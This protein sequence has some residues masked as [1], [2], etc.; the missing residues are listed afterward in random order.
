MLLRKLFGTD[1][2]ISYSRAD[3]EYAKKLKEQ[4]ASMDYSCFIDY[5]KVFAGDRLSGALRRAI[6]WSSVLVLIGTEKSRASKFVGQEV[7][8][9]LKTKRPMVPICLGGALA[10]S[11]W[12]VIHDNDFVWVDEPNTA[13]P[14]PVVLDE[15]NRLFKHNRVKVWRRTAGT[16]LTL[17]LLALSAFAAI[18]AREARAQQALAEQKTKEAEQKTRDLQ[19]KQGELEAS[20][21]RLAEQR[22]QLKKQNEDLEKSK[23]ELLKKTEEARANADRARRQEQLARSNAARAREQQLLAEARQKEALSREVASSALSL[24]ASDPEL[25]V[26]LA[27]EALNIKDTDQAQ[28]ALR[29]AVLAFPSRAV[30]CEHRGVV[31]TG[32]FSAD[33]R[34]AVTGSEEGLARV[35]DVATGAKVAEVGVA[36]APVVKAEFNPKAD[37]LLTLDNKQ[38]ARLWEVQGQR[39]LRV[40]GTEGEARAAAFSPDG[41]SVLTTFGDH[42]A[43]VYATREGRELKVLRGHTGAV[44]TAEF[45]RDGTL[46]VTTGGDGTARVWSAQTGEEL[47]TLSAKEGWVR[48]AS[49]GDPSFDGAKF[50]RDGRLVITQNW[51][52]VRVWDWRRG[53]YVKIGGSKPGAFFSI[54]FV[55]LSPDGRLVATGGNTDVEPVRLWK[56]SDG[57]KVLETDISNV[58]SLEFSPDGAYLLLSGKSRAF[59]T[60]IGWN[61]DRSGSRVQVWDVNAGRQVFS[62]DGHTDFVNSARFSPDG[63]LI[64]TAGDDQT[65]RVWRFTLGKRVTELPKTWRLDATAFSPDGRYIIPRGWGT[66]HD[67][68]VWETHT[69]RQWRNLKGHDRKVLRASFS[70]DGKK[71]VSASV[72]NTA[73]VWDAETGTVLRTF[74]KHIDQFEDVAEVGLNDVTFNHD[75]TLIATAGNDH[76]ARLWEESTGKELFALPHKG[77]VLSVAFSPSG[78]YLATSAKDDTVHVWDVRTGKEVRSLGGEPDQVD[79]V[80][81]SPLGNYILLRREVLSGSPELWE[82]RAGGVVQLPGLGSSRL[83]SVELSA[84]ERFIVT[85]GNDQTA[86]VWDVSTRKQLWVLPGHTSTVS[87]ATFSPDGR[88]I[89]TGSLDGKVWVWDARAQRKV[90]EVRANTWPV[91]YAGFSPDGNFI[92]TRNEDERVRIYPWE[93]FAPIEEVLR[94]SQGSTRR[95]LTAGEK[96]DY[97]HVPRVNGPWVAPPNPHDGSCVG[98][99]P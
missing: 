19:I 82:W 65:A 52:D 91:N 14:S 32:S 42:T 38:T 57:S 88:Y 30:L 85:A 9:F 89:V 80:E 35:W 45:S 90:A 53:G 31:R 56:T 78:E 2:F 24:T 59:E 6:R 87:S 71:I 96:E 47:K 8:E 77:K 15:I 98:Q 73:K 3:K 4:L 83:L 18:Q 64:L 28:A 5:E 41:E 66:D 97:L 7:D 62:L 16:G 1:I 61:V 50:S 39:M 94:L 37:L 40:V 72:D 76:I 69:G 86:R 60:E 81:F 84:D 26:M 95:Q 29:A 70:P 49:E 20:T 92:I 13:A 55:E 12:A 23:V 27:R 34:L 10:T 58:L 74:G 21:A 43:R 79:Q 33:S 67:V 93:I 68:G 46:I 63:K 17:V 25:S 11:D 54:D 99:R 75:G 22:E 36:G 44:H 51:K 48:V